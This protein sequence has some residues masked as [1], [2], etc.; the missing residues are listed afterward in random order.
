MLVGPAATAVA[1]PLGLMVA[2]PGAD[3][4][5]VTD[6]V[7]SC[8]VLFEKLPTALNCCVVPAAMVGVDGI[9]VTETR[10]AVVVGVSPS[11]PV[12]Q[13]TKARG[14]IAINNSSQMIFEKVSLISP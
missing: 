6:E 12:P 7:R 10:V 3:E 2:K 8:W 4:L 5:Q 9:T 13:F 11:T 1:S 14:I